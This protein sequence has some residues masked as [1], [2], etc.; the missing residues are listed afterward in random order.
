MDKLSIRLL[1]GFEITGGHHAGASA[2]SRK[3]KAVLAFVALQPDRPQSRE[4][5]A[6]L[7]WQNSPE[8]Q[9]RTNLRQTLAALRK[10]LGAVLVTEGDRV[11]IDESLLDVDAARF[12]ECLSTGDLAALEEATAI[13]Q[14]DLLEGFSIKEE[15]FEAWLAPLRERYRSRMIDGLIE[16]I[17]CYEE[18]QGVAQVLEAA[19]RLL[20]LDPLNEAAHRS[21]MRAYAAQGRH[22]AALKQFALCREVL[23][24]ELG[25]RP[26]PETIQ[27]VQELRA[28]RA[29]GRA[30]PPSAQPMAAESPGCDREA[31]APARIG[32]SLPDKPSIAVL[33]FQDIS[34]HSEPEYFSDG[35]TAD[36]ITELSRFSELFVIARQS[37]FSYKGSAEDL[38]WI[39]HELGVRYILDGS[40]RRAGKRVRI[41]AQLVDLETGNHIWTERYDR[42]LKDIFDLQEEITR[43]IVASIAPQIEI[44]EMKRVRSIPVADLSAYDLALKAQS[45]L[46][47]AARMGSAEIF[48]QAIETARESLVRDSRNLHALGTLAFAHLMQFSYHWGGAK[49]Q[50]LNLSWEAVQR[51]F[52]IDPSYPLAYT[53]RGEIRIFRGEYDAALSDFRHAYA[54]NPNFAWNLFFLACAEAVTGLTEQA[55]EHA[56]LGL[57]LSPRDKEFGLGVAHMALFEAGF[58]E[59]DFEQAKAWGTR[60]TQMHPRAKFGRALMIACCGHLG[61]LDEAARHAAEL[62][63]FAPDFLPS[64]FRGELFFYR[65]PEHTA[66]LLEGLRKAGLR[67]NA[68]GD[69]G[70]DARSPDARPG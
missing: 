5:L 34:G 2:V 52:E 14:G 67:T 9:A 65:L 32:L 25:V 13:Y 7:F 47:E 42:E 30:P 35:I 38:K 37:S 23:S 19:P 22:S 21:L 36:I 17:G 56:E 68:G 16:M 24:R 55:R 51:L 39:G 58:A 43:N 63:S 46:Y 10:R 33:P 70:V 12:E 60:I 44:A 1:G 4:L 15:A 8:A 49:D 20:A 26:Q 3:A 27:L 45:L 61:D 31:A 6:A 64:I 57:R 41:N 53:L 50:S 48:E 59:G 11:A 69:V 29:K 28:Q 54:L 40:V 66:L 18:T 62:H